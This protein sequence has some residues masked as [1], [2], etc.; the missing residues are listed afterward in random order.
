VK[1]YLQK[2]KSRGLKQRLRE[3]AFRI[4]RELRGR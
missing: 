2:I 3:K 4:Q 1:E